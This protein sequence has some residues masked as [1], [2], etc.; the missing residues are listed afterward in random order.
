M[1]NAW[2]RVS[3]VDVGE[4]SGQVVVGAVVNGDLVQNMT[5]FVRGQ[6]PMY[7]SS[8]EVSDRV[9]CYVPARN[10]DLVVKELRLN[11]AIGLVGSPGSGR[12]TT[13]IAAMHQLRPAIQSDGS[14]WKMTMPK[15]S[16]P[17]LPAAVV[18]LLVDPA[19][20]RNAEPSAPCNL[21]QVSDELLGQCRRPLLRRSIP[22]QRRGPRVRVPEVSSS[23]VNR[24]RRLRWRV[25]V[26]PC[27]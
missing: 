12:Q 22:M 23:Q 27:P 15:R 14:P 20:P 7:L 17:Q 21:K 26:P 1:T 11:Q 4:D 25:L 19:R 18:G 13:A 9:A 24:C 2:V 6:P 5:T 8:A 16:T 3:D 10:H